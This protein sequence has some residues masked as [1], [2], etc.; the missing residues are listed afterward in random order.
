MQEIRISSWKFVIIEIIVI[1]FIA[2][3]TYYGS[4]L[5]FSHPPSTTTSTSTV[6]ALS[7]TTINQTQM[8]PYLTL[9]EV[10]GIFGSNNRNATYNANHC[11]PSNSTNP[12]YCANVAFFSPKGKFVGWIIQFK[13]SGV[14][15][16]EILLLNSKNS[17]STYRSVTK[18]IYPN[19]TIGYYPSN[20]IINATENG[21]LYSIQF[22]D[23]YTNIYLIKGNDS[24]FVYLSGANYSQNYTSKIVSAISKKM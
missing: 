23:S 14:D 1:A 13:Y 21:A 18:P 5:Q 7:T 8:V 20:A 22:G 16:N 17:S 6:P 10:Q 2:G 15:L 24:A 12:N 11:Q 19:A 4:S 9:L 3:L